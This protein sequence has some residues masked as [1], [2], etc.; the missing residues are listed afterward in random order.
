MDSGRVL[1]ALREQEKWRE[2]RDRLAERL[3]A[4]QARKRYLQ[5]ELDTVRRSAARL[6]MIVQGLKQGR[7][8]SERASMAHDRFV[9]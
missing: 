9:R 1:T 2:R 8:P 3:R 6:E 7:A 5:R 4:V